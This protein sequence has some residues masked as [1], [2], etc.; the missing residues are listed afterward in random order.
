M[1][2]LPLIEVE[3]FIVKKKN[4]KYTKEMKKRIKK[5]NLK[6]EMLDKEI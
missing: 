4:L 1:V 6:N 3:T 5:E 2:Y